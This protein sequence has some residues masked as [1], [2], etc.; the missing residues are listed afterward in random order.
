MAHAH[1]RA[2]GESGLNR[3]W[4]AL[5]CCG[6]P[7]LVDLPVMSLVYCILGYISDCEC[8]DDLVPSLSLS[9]CVCE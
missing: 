2:L 4:R 3:P 9:L 1:S 8:C 7:G 6:G 5:Q